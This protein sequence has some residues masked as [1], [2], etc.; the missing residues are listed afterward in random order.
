MHPLYTCMSDS[1]IPHYDGALVT[2]SNTEYTNDAVLVHQI[3][4]VLLK[5]ERNHRYVMKFFWT[6]QGFHPVLPL[7]L[8]NGLK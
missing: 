2:I 4:Q 8:E 3:E 5:R 1:I 7:V 6:V